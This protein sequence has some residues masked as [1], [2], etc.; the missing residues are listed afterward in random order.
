VFVNGPFQVDPVGGL[1]EQ[2]QPRTAD[3]AGE[4]LRPKSR[5][6]PV[7]G[8][9]QPKEQAEGRRLS[10]AVRSQEPVHV[11]SLHAQVHVIDGREAA[12]AFH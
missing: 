7:S 12:A 1:V 3:E 5:I 10:C 4:G 2:E 11:S 6:E 9:H 8:L